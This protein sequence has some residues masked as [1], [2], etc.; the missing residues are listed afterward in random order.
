MAVDREWTLLEGDAQLTIRSDRRDHLPYGLAGGGPGSGSINILRRADGE[1]ELPV[2]VSTPMEAGETIYHQQP[3]GGGFGDP[4][5][6]E[7]DAVAIDVRDDRVSVQAAR[8][9]YG[10]LLDHNGQVDI[11]GTEAL[12]NERSG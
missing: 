3:G 10:V 2:M 4:F 12:R 7:P 5:T 11:E 1:V 9:E 8:D 6:R